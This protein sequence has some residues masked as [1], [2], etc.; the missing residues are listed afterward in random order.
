MSS[1][2]WGTPCAPWGNARRADSC[3]RPEQPRS[4]GRSERDEKDL[5]GKPG[6]RTL[7]ATGAHTARPGT[8]RVVQPARFRR[9]ERH[10]PGAQNGALLASWTRRL[11]VPRMVRFW[12]AEPR[13]SGAQ[14][15]S[16]FAVRTICLLN[17]FFWSLVWLLCDYAFG[18][19]VQMPSPYGILGA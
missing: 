7:R 11:T 6:A 15:A 13:A 3:P 5:T 10:D 12:R 8:S 14:T 1:V 19:E 4:S 16:L 17:L 2:L 18:A 9:A